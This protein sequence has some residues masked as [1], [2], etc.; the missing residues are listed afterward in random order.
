MF[1]APSSR[2]QVRQKPNLSRITA[3]LEINFGLTEEYIRI[4]YLCASGRK[5]E[6]FSDASA[7]L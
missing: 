6:F 2:A 5:I 4:K 1:F 7:E 3:I